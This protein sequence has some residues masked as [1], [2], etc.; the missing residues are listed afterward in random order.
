MGEVTKSRYTK[1]TPSITLEGSVGGRVSKR[2]LEVNADG[3]R[4]EKRVSLEGVAD[5]TLGEEA[6]KDQEF[7]SRAMYDVGELFKEMSLAEASA[8]R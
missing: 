7:R 5:L 4:R 2:R 6:N 1:A 8:R 3:E